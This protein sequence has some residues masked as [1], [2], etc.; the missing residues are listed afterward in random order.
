MVTSIKNQPSTI[1]PLAPGRR[2]DAVF[3]VLSLWFTGGL[4]LDGWA[5][6]LIFSGGLGSITSRL[7]QEPEADQFAR[8]AVGMGVPPGRITCTGTLG[9]LIRQAADLRYFLSILPFFQAL[10]AFA[11]GSWAY[12]RND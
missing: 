2:F 11:K 8:I 4:F 7:W 9:W 1:L 12:T 6:L 10:E 5:P 3:A